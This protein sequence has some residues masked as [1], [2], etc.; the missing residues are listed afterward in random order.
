MDW[1]GGGTDAV[2]GYAFL[3]SRII[4]SENL[5][6]P[7][8]RSA[9]TDAIVAAGD[10]QFHQ[11]GSKGVQEGDPNGETSVTPAWRKAVSHFVSGA[12]PTGF[13]KE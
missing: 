5:A 2:G 11:V 4:Q 1:H 9:L 10:G 3:S 7:E 13:T 8:A 12:F 6:T